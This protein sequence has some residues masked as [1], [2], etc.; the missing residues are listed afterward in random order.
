[1]PLTEADVNVAYTAEVTRREAVVGG[2][3]GATKPG[4]RKMNYNDFL[5]G[6]CVMGMGAGTP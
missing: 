4:D 5:T 6:A 1:V 2:A 3:A